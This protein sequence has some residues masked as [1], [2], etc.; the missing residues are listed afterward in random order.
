MQSNYMLGGPGSQTRNLLALGNGTE[1]VNFHFKSVE[2]GLFRTV[3]GS[4]PNDAIRVLPISDLPTQKLLVIV[5]HKS[6]D[7]P[8]YLPKTMTS[9]GNDPLP[10]PYKRFSNSALLRPNSVIHVVVRMNKKPNARSVLVLSC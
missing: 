7:L 8:T 5:C 6:L 1:T 2:V 4:F 10:E 9:F 3:L